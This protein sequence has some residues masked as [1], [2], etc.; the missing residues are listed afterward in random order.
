LRSILLLPPLQRLTDLPPR[1]PASRTSSSASP[2]PSA[3][4]PSVPQRAQHSVC[5]Q[6]PRAVLP[7]LRAAAAWA[8][9]GA[10]GPT[11]AGARAPTPVMVTVV[12]SPGAL[13][14]ARDLE[15]A[16]DLAS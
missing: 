11:A 13:A 14:V 8:H 15:A 3:P 12:C 6:P 2:L 9:T 16:A 4:P 1:C 7:A 5:L 10:P